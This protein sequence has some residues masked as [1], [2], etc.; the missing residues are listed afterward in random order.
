MSESGAGTD[1]LGMSTT[2][3]PTAD[4]KGFIIN[5]S[6]MWITNGTLSGTDT[7][8]VFLL[9]AKTGKG[10]GVGDLTSF[11]GNKISDQIRYYTNICH[12]IA[13]IILQK[14]VIFPENRCCH[15]LPELFTHYSYTI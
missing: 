5:G 4:N 14:Y 1:V 11:L 15:L 6:K 9:Y 10:R 3:T 7:G 13:C 12:S 8:D 2:A